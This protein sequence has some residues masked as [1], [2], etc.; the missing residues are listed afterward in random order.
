MG[1]RDAPL[2][3]ILRVSCSATSIVAP[4]HTVAEAYRDDARKGASPMPDLA[5]TLTV[6]QLADIVVVSI[7]VNPL[8]F[9]ANEDLDAYPRTMTADKEKLFSEGVQVLYAPQAEEI[10]P[11]GMEAQTIV[12]I[13]WKG[14]PFAR[15]RT[16]L[17]GPFWLSAVYRK[18]TAGCVTNPPYFDHAGT[19]RFTAEELRRAA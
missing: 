9:G 7:F 15:S 4:S 12:H 3:L 14:K 16:L 17:R 11:K 13:R 18:L 1:R 8:Q 5:S 19:I 2:P 10:Y 6:R